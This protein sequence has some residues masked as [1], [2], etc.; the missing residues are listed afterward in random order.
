MTNLLSAISL[1]LVF[2]AAAVEQDQKVVV[3]AVGDIMMDR[4]VGYMV[5]RE[6]G[7]DFR[8][9]FFETK[10][11]LEKADILF[12]NLENVI[13]DKGAKVGSI[14]SFRANPE[15][16]EGLKY[17]GFDVVSVANNHSFDYGRKA[18][19]DTFFRLKDAGIEY[20]GGGFSEQ[21]AFSVKIKEVK[22]AKLG[23]MGYTNLGAASWAAKGENSG[24]A[25]IGQQDLERVRQDVGEAKS[26]V[27]ILFV[28]FH[29]GD[30]YSPTPNSFQELW[31]RELID[32]GADIILG[33]HPH[34]VQPIEKYK[35]GW[36]AYSLGNFVF[37]QGFSEETMTGAL[38]EVIIQNKKI[39]E[40]NQKEVKMTPSFQPYF[41]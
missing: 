2:A 15:A 14:Y 12:G 5:N 10:D 23:F 9:P 40:V 28:S 29:W 41:P 19:E 32:S 8:F 24:I 20:T 33:H 11:Y 17:A 35:D 34:V 38:L 1:V 13:S 21:E 6:G 37:D 36:I 30:E 27:D 31:A 39:K 26:R 25:R 7:G 22:G 18:L 3:A 16:A 4:G